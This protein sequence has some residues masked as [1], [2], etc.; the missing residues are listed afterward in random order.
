[1]K[2]ALTTIVAFAGRRIDAP[3]ATTPRFPLTQVDVVQKK[4]EVRNTDTGDDTYGLGF[5]TYG[6]GVVRKQTR[7]ICEWMVECGT[8]F[9]Y[10]QS[11]GD[12]LLD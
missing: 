9:S 8:F 12:C 10:T 2:K 6:I 5:H 3:D 7:G 11:Q 4:I 1:M